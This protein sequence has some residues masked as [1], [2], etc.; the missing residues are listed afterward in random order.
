MSNQSDT[1]LR[2]ILG[3]S[4]QTASMRAILLIAALAFVGSGCAYLLH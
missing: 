2:T 4:L 1:I 3:P